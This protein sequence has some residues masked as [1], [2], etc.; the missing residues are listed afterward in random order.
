MGVKERR[1]KYPYTTVG[2][3]LSNSNIGFTQSRNFGS[4]NSLK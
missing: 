3:A 4:A 2:T 1:A